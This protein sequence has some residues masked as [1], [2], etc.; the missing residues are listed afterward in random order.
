M[1]HYMDIS[2]DRKR[3]HVTHMSCTRTLCTS[4]YVDKLSKNISTQ[5]FDIA[6]P[7]LKMLFTLMPILPVLVVT[8]KDEKT[9]YYR[10]HFL[11]FTNNL[12]HNMKNYMNAAAESLKS[13]YWDNKAVVCILFSDSPF[14]I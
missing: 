13:K 4:L 14:R 3:E 12:A 1:K 6:L 8:E 5:I 2:E 11:F 10:T 7:F 9:G